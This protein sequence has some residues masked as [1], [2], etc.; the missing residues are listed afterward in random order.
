MDTAQI[1]KLS[2]NVMIGSLIGA[3]G[4]A[5]LAIL[6]GEFNDILWRALFTFLIVTGHAL[7]SLGFIENNTK[8]TGPSDLKVFTNT[9]FTL[10]ILSFITAV[11]GA[12]ELLPGEIV[13]KLYATYFIAAFATLHGE[14]LYKTTGLESRIDGIVYANYIFMA[15]VMLLLLPLVWIGG[16]QFEGFYYRLLAASAVVDATLTILA[17]ILHRLYLQKNPE[18]KSQLF[19]EVITYDANGHPVKQQVAE[20]RR[21]T[22][23]LLILLGLYLLLQFLS[24]LVWALFSFTR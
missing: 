24:P 21:R 9:I 8:K 11:F 14:M 7:A 6:V 5:V 12:W 20:Q 15:I 23:P 22:H 2:V 17:I 16:T 4:I 13:A 19:T 1:K 10:I 18:L 3:A